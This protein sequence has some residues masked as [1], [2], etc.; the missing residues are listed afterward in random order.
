[1]FVLYQALREHSLIAAAVNCQRSELMLPLALDLEQHLTFR[2]FI[3]SLKMF[4]IFLSLLLN[5]QLII[6]LKQVCL[7]FAINCIV[8]HCCTFR[9]LFFFNVIISL[10]AQ[11]LFFLLLLFKSLHS[12]CELPKLYVALKH[13]ISRIVKILLINQK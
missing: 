11:F 7:H 9:F 4:K 13:F 6:K 1:M 3:L 2:T 5:L 12:S 8:T 10:S